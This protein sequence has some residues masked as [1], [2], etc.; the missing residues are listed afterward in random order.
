M[1]LPD[2]KEFKKVERALRSIASEE[3]RAV[4]R[5]ETLFRSPEK[6]GSE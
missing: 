1:A 4:F 5:R 6:G 3:R 2:G